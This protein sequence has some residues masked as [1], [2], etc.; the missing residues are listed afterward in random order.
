MGM[1]I[2][3]IKSARE[4]RLER[5]RHERERQD[6][7]ICERLECEVNTKRT[8]E[9]AEYLERRLQRIEAYRATLAAAFMGRRATV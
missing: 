8:R 7:I 5:D 9:R 4:L 1:Q 2:R 6:K 3:V